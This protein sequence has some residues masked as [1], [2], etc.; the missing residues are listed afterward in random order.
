MFDF[1]GQEEWPYLRAA[2]VNQKLC[3]AAHSQKL[4]H[5][6]PSGQ[7]MENIHVGFIRGVNLQR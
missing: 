2:L 5:L 3:R 1:V 4:R 7:S 6:Y